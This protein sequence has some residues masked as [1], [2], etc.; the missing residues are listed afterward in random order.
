MWDEFIGNALVVARLRELAASGAGART[1]VLA[2]PEGIGKTRLALMYGLA[3]NC[4]AAPAP[5][6]ACGSCASCRQAIAADQIQAAIEA[7]LEHRAAEVKTNPREAAPLRVSLHPAIFLYPPDGDFFSLPQAR[8]AIHQSQ[9]QPDSGAVWTLI[10]PELDQAR[11]TT[12][13]A[14]LKTLEEPPPRVALVVLARNPLALLP[15][16]R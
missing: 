15:T 1:L 4:L 11:W 7:G 10:L 5:G 12:Q 6:V 8:S 16:V 3:L 14:L 2:G 13:A 9:L